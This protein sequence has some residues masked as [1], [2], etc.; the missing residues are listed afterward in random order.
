MSCW[1]ALFKMHFPFY[2]VFSKEL[3]RFIVDIYDTK[4]CT[5]YMS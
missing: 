3:T 1:L 2:D 4:I 5:L